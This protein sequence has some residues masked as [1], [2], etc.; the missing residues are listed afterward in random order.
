[1]GYNDLVSK[2]YR[3]LALMG[4][5]GFGV[6]IAFTV[7]PA[8]HGESYL[9]FEFSHICTFFIAIFLVLRALIVVY[10]AH[11]AA[12]GLWRAHN[13][14][15]GKLILLHDRAMES[16]DFD[17]LLYRYLGIFS[18][19]RRYVEYTIIEEYFYRH[20]CISRAEFRF[21]D[22][23]TRRYAIILIIFI[24]SFF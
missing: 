17:G 14:S 13:L 6:L 9:A 16:S 10:N 15:A 1:M 22:Y 11:H 2:L 19:L 4:C 18:P 24:D 3:E 21:V 5:I 23:L 20:Y 12:S 7:F 8:S